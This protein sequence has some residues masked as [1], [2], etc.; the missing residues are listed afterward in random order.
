MP[1]R[2]DSGG[3]RIRMGAPS[4]RSRTLLLTLAI[5]VVIV[6]AWVLFANFWTDWLWYKSVG[7]GNVFTTKLWTRIGLFLVFGLLMAVAVGVNVYIAYRLRP[8]F[9]G[10]SLE[11]QSLDRYRSA[12]TP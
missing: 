7:Y 5:L 9:R 2:G 8:A 12:I 10:M 1:E 3:R 4:R 6:V 11:Q